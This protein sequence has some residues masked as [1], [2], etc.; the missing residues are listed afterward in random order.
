MLSEPQATK[1][2]TSSAV[3][4]T[5]TSMPRVSSGPNFGSF[6]SQDGY[7]KL[8]VQHQYGKRTRRNVRM[9][10]TVLK[11]DPLVTGLSTY[12]SASAYLVLDHPPAAFTVTELKTFVEYLVAWLEESTFS[13]TIKVLGGES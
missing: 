9:D 5:V 12:Q 1:T 4:A 10:F 6:Q 7:T 3:S 13:N 8:T 11:A 2:V